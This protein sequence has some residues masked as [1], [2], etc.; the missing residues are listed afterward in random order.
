M[1]YA[2][3]HSA[4]LDGITCGALAKIAHPDINLIGY[5]YGQPLHEI[6]AMPDGSEVYMMDVSLKKEEMFKLGKRVDLIWIDH[7]KSAMVE[8][9]ESNSNQQLNHHVYLYNDGKNY[10][11]IRY[12]HCNF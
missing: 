12:I 6:E 11:S 3:Y 1:K 7:H 2:I 4:D 10:K 8:V 9:M 5:D